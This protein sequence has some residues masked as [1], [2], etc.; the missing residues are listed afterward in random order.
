[1]AEE[2]QTGTGEAEA[3]PAQMT[4]AEETAHKSGWRPKEDWNGD[5]DEWVEAKEFNFRGELMGRISEQSSILSNFKNQIAERDQTIGDLVKHH[6]SVSER[7]Y[8]KALKTLKDAKIEAIDDGDGSAVVEL[9]NE[10][11][12]L[13]SRKAEVDKVSEPTNAAITDTTPKEVVDWLQK[14]QN[15]WYVNDPFLKSVADGI[16]KD[17]MQQTPNVTPDNLLRKMDAKMREELPHKFEGSPSVNENEPDDRT[18]TSAN[19]KGGKRYGMKDLD[20]TQQECAKRFIKTGVMTLKE[21][22]D[23]LKA[24][25][26]L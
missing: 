2:E 15:K 25:G 9:D 19:G 12:E 20:E 13:K 23:D 7:E 11:D 6:K 1:M 14:P 18:N 21:Y 4:A 24:I 3:A 5:P 22:I 17:I 10:I 8:K 16:A 26:E